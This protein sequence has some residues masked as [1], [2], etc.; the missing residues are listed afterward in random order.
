MAIVR[1]SNEQE[2]FMLYDSFDN[3]FIG[4][5][6]TEPLPTFTRSGQPIEMTVEGYVS[7]ANQDVNVN[8]NSSIYDSNNPQI[9]YPMIVGGRPKSRKKTSAKSSKKEKAE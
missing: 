4:I 1:L 9:Q 7:E 3:W 2:F 8:F 5:G 6:T